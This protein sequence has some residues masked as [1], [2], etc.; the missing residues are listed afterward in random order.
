M[1]K[2]DFFNKNL[3]EEPV[4]EI[5]EPVIEKI[6]L[7][8][9]EYSQDELQKLVGLGKIGL[10]AEQRYNRSIDKF[11]PEYTK[12]RQELDDLKKQQSERE[13]T[14]LAQK[15]QT[16][17]QLSPEELRKQA[18]SQAEE[19]GLVH[20]GN[21]RQFINETLAARDLLEEAEM[22]IE[23]EISVGKP[24]TTVEELLKHMEETGIRIP[25]KAYKDKFETEI[26]KWKEI[27]LAKVKQSGLETQESSTAGAKQ[28]PE[29]TPL[30]KDT[31]SDALRNYVANRG[32]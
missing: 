21:I 24:K 9:D 28:P 14:E 3:K 27:Q 2:D 19:L 15:V 6:K 32:Q 23:Q 7:G 17:E 10:E 18:L 16:G 1:A 12:T 4:E 25:A 8:E 26:D 31:L 20:K 5:K 30:T 22:V 13:Q 29:R 11:W